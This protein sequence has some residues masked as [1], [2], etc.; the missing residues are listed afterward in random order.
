MRPYRTVVVILFALIVG[1]ATG[2][3]EDPQTPKQSLSDKDKQ[4]IEELN[5][6]RQEEWKTKKGPGL[7]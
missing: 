4:Q 5:K 1:V 6:Q 7:Q 3:G 2:C